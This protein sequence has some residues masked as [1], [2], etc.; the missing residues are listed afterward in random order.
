LALPHLDI[1]QFLV[2]Q[3]NFS[4][5]EEPA[6]GLD[7]QLVLSHLTQL[8]KLVSPKMVAKDEGEEEESTDRGVM[9]DAEIKRMERRKRKEQMQ[10]QQSSSRLGVVDDRRGSF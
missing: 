3:L 2:G 4:L 1:L 9:T 8:L 7:P 6:D 10:K 5:S